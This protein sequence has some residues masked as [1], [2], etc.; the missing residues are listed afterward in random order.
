[1]ML[2]QLLLYSKVT[3]SH[4]YEYFFFSNIIFHHGLSQE[5]LDV[6]PCAIEQS[7]LLLHSKCNPRTPRPSP[8]LPHSLGNHKSVLHVVKTQA[9][10]SVLYLGYHS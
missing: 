1:M 10:F 8:S 5:Q 4:I 6:F 2:C 7:S 3:Q 9:L